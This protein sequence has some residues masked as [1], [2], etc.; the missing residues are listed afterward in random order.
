MVDRQGSARGRAGAHG[1]TD[2]LAEGEALDKVLGE[3][4]VS[5]TGRSAIIGVRDGRDCAG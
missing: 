3:T 2:G 5:G 4:L 1:E